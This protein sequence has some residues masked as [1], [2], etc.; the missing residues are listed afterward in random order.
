MAKMQEIENSAN[1][2]P[3]LK[4]NLQKLR[5][6]KEDLIDKIKSDKNNP[7]SENWR[8]KVEKIEE[9]EGKMKENLE[10]Q[11]EIPLLKKN[12][13]KLQ[14]KNRDLE[15]NLRMAEN[16][17]SPDYRRLRDKIE[18]LKRENEILKEERD[19]PN[20]EL[21]KALDKFENEK[22]RYVFIKNKYKIFSI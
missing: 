6:E 11:A 5:N 18:S 20:E 13:R 2:V 16:V 7:E 15:E 9:E 21:A 1:L 4:K 14:E 19:A 3:Q 8:K 12:I 17:Q 10:N 22:E